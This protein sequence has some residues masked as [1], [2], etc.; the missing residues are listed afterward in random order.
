LE[1]NAFALL[2]TVDGR[3]AQFHTSWTQ[4]KNRFTFE[5]FGRDGFVRVEGLG[6]SYG[7]E[8]LEIGR[9]K[10]EGGSPE[11]E[12]FEFPGPDLSWQAEWQEFTSAIREGRQPLANG[13]DG[14]QAMRLIAAIYESA[15]TGQVV[16]LESG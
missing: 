13:E 16:R 12:T 10:T 2:R 4:W 9:R 5:V 3:V 1:D 14:L 11:V 7:T 8:R 15:R 6:G